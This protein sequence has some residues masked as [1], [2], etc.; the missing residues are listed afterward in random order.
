MRRD[1]TPLDVMMSC[2]TFER[3]PQRSDNIYNL[4]FKWLSAQ[5][6]PWKSLFT[7]VR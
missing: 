6:I 2:W 7:L 3:Q 1:N 4:S 5:T